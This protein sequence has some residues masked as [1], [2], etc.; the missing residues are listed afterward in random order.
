[1]PCTPSYCDLHDFAVAAPW[2][3]MAWANRERDT[4]HYPTM[5][6]VRR[7]IANAMED[8]PEEETVKREGAYHRK[9]SP[10]EPTVQWREPDR[11][12]RGVKI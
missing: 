8:M 11:P 1:M 10:K 2:C 12:F 4:Q 5:D 9:D 3:A 6:D 7:E